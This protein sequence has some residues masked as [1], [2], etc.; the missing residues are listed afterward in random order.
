MSLCA[1]CQYPS[2]VPFKRVVLTAN[3]EEG[4]EWSGASRGHLCWNKSWEALELAGCAQD[5]MR[6]LARGLLQ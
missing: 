6:L 4:R 2:L 3:D 1:E 5:V